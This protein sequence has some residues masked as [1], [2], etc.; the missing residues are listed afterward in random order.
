MTAEQVVEPEKPWVY[1]T[2]YPPAKSYRYKTLAE[3]WD[4]MTEEQR[5]EELSD[6]ALELGWLGP[7]D[8]EETSREQE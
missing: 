7:Y 4:T 8:Y 1:L 6:A 2:I 5:Q 3:D